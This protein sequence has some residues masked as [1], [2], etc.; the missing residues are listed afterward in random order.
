MLTATS[1]GGQEAAAELPETPNTKLYARI[2]R[3]IIKVHSIFGAPLH[4]VVSG[5]GPGSGWG[6][7][8][9]YNA[10]S[11]GPWHASAKAVFALNDN[12]VTEGIVGYRAR[13]AEVESF[14]RWRQLTR[15]DYFGS[16]PNSQLFNRT[17]F[18][19]RDPVV[20]AHGKFR[21]TPAVT[22]GGRVEEIWPYANEGRRLPSIESRFFPADAPGLFVR[23]RYGRYQGSV[24]IQLPAAAGDA[25]YQGTRTRATYAIYDHQDADAFN[26]RRFDIEA[27]QVFGGFAA[28]H[29]LT[30]SGWAATLTAD[31]GQ[32]IPFF[33][34]PTLGGKSSIRG[35]HEDRLGSDGTEATLR[36]YRD[37]R[38]RDRN[39]L[40]LQA[41]YR[42]PLW[43]PI[44][45]TLFADAGKVARTQSEVDL[46]DLRRDVGFSLSVMKGWSTWARVDVGFGSGEGARV[47]F[48]LGELTP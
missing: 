28:H 24:D 5:I 6:I 42:V 39:L 18:S 1:T 21:V 8:L 10:P 46:N 12:W 14:A 7:G 45:G 29:R 4:P 16:G 34:Q 40:L 23:P 22:I 43:G 26:F 38:F 2:E 32:Q 47:F 37:L 13:R 48:S 15:V 31:A 9:G 20:G 33:M 25:F 30:L 41:E 3:A 35:V 44:D 17:S 36:G 27:K 11:R 19:Y